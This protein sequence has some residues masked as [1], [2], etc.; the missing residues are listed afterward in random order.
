LL[1]W[2]T[3]GSK[4][5]DPFE[6]E[7]GAVLLHAKFPHLKKIVGQFCWLKEDRLGRMYDL[8]DTRKTWLEITRIMDG[9]LRLRQGGEFPARKGPLCG[10]CADTTC[11]HNPNSA[12]AVA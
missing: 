7:V 8:S 4:Y 9:I 5:E 10:W 3:G 1:D 6:L 2:K 12:K 11:E